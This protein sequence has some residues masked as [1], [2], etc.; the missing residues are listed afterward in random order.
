MYLS[1]SHYLSL[2]LSAHLRHAAVH[3]AGGRW[4]T[5]A[6]RSAGDWE[7]AAGWGRAGAGCVPGN[8]GHERGPHSPGGKGGRSG[9]GPATRGSALAS[10]R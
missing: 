10:V 2:S 6:K 9:P 3:A 4:P 1:L 5:G 7:P 8:P